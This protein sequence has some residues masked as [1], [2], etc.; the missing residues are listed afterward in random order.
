MYQITTYFKIDSAIPH[1][2]G[3][4][5]DQNVKSW[6]VVVSWDFVY[7]ANIKLNIA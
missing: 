1:K 4:F 5:F 2:M 6:L 7:D 3:I